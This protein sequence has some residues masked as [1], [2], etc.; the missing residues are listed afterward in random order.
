MN[1][2]CP[3]WLKDYRFFQIFVLGILSG[4]PFSILYTSMIAWM[5]DCNIELALI[6]SFAVA[7][8]P[9]SLKVFWSPA[10]DYFKIPLLHRLGQKKSWMMVSAGIIAISLFFVSRLNPTESLTDLRYIAIMIGICAAT[11]DLGC[12]AIRINLL[13]SEEQGL[14]SATAVLGWRLGAYLT[15]GLTLYFVGQNYDLWSKVFVIMGV[16]FAFSVIFISTIKEPRLF[17]DHG[18]N[19][20]QRFHDLAVKPFVEILSRR[21]ALIILASIVCYKMGE[22]MLGFV[23]M[24]FYKHLGYSNEQIGIMVKTYG[25][26]ATTFGSI[27]GGMVV[28]RM[29]NVKGMIVCGLLQSFSN[30]MYLWLHH[31]D[32]S[33]SALLTAVSIDNFT[34]GMGSTALVSYLSALC[35]KT[36]SASQYALLSSLSTLANNA[37]SAE[38][39]KIIDL[40]GWDPFFIM[41]VVL[42]FPALILLLYIGKKT[43]F[44]FN[45]KK[46]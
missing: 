6:T 9:Y 22:A 13:S 29:G 18:G 46:E 45:D 17:A 38:S 36:Y 44:S 21:G 32:V 3:I 11:Y 26:L 10:I 4:M 12:D 33:N 28:Y 27:A 16:V 34:G 25:V 1:V 14:G 30:L 40:F 5:K 20:Y 7:R 35:N 2:K 41:T 19:F 31:Q 23:S 24:P 39:G 43:L 42:E 37:L 15:G 8:L